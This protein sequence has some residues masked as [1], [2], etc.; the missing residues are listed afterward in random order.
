VT[1]PLLI[2][3]AAAAAPGFTE[4]RVLEATAAPSLPRKP[5]DAAWDKAAQKT[6]K[7]SAQRSVRLSDAEANALLE[8]PGVGAVKVRALAAGGEVAV[9][10]EWSDATLDKVRDD[11]VNLYADAVALETPQDFGAGKR[12]PYIGMGDEKSPVKLWQQKATQSG[13]QAAAFVGMGFGS[14]TRAGSAAPAMEY[15][16]AAKVWRAVFVIP[17]PQGALVPVA[18]AVWDGSRKERAGYKQLSGWNFLQLPGAAVDP[19]Y[20]AEQSWGYGG[21]PLGNAEL[22]KVMAHAVCAVCHHFPGVKKV[23]ANLAPDMAD[24]GA[25]ATPGYLRDS[26]VDPRA[27]VVHHLPLARRY[28]KEGQRDANGAY[29][30]ATSFAWAMHEDGGTVSRMPP[31]SGFAESQVKDLVAYLMTLQG[32]TR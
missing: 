24:I 31:F 12:L 22:G 4:A 3:L 30:A 9:R 2:A 7:V 5:G 14:L 23:P 1:L 13:A 17:R 25:I 15:D 18:F 29:P 8:V 6:F 19:K 32:D 20:L 21:A 11:E 27:A 28:D 10:V 26:I 16:A